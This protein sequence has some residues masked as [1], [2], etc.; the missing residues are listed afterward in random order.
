MAGSAKSSAIRSRSARQF[1]E[2]WPERPAAKRQ[3]REKWQAP[4]IGRDPVSV[5]EGH[6]LSRGPSGPPRSGMSGKMAGSANRA[7]SGL[8]AKA[9]YGAVARAAGREAAGAGKMACSR[10]LRSKGRRLPRPQ[11]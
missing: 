7:R 1:A 8:S 2:P 11:P 10:R 5:G 3:E 6:L 4:Q 9:F